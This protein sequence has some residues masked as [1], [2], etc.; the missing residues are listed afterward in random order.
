MWN[1]V[2]ASEAPQ[3]AHFIVPIAMFHR[4]DRPRLITQCRALCGVTECAPTTDGNIQWDEHLIQKTEIDSTYRTR[5]VA[6]PELRWLIRNR[7]ASRQLL[8]LCSLITSFPAANGHPTRKRKKMNTYFDISPWMNW[9]IGES[10]D[11]LSS[12]SLWLIQS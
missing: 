1:S 4:A 10:T 11:H 2:P 8:W 7:Q 3:L 6:L 12:M 9:R 5:L